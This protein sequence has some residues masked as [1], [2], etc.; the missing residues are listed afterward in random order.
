MV[1][2]LHLIAGYPGSQLDQ[3]HGWSSESLG[4]FLYTLHRR[5][6]AGCAS[7]PFPELVAYAAECEEKGMKMSERVS[8]LAEELISPKV[9]PD[10]L[11]DIRITRKRTTII[12]HEHGLSVKNA[13]GEKMSVESEMKD[14]GWDRVLIRAAWDLSSM[15][16]FVAQVVNAQDSD[17]SIVNAASSGTLHVFLS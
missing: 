2:Y 15:N 4:R 11:E 5:F 6:T 3:M 1:A 13:K 16:D 7:Y 17:N 10:V 8:S 9:R 12:V 14:L